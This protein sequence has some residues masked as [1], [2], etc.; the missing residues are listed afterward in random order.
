MH[1]NYCS[2]IF[3]TTTVSCNT[4]LEMGTVG[5]L[6]HGNIITDEKTYILTDGYEVPSDGKVIAW[7][8]CYRTSDVMPV[9]FYPGIW[10]IT[11]VK[12]NGD[13]DYELVQSNAITYDPSKSNNPFSCLT[14]NLSETDQYVVS[15]GSFVGLYSHIGSSL[16][17]TS[18]DDSLI[19]YE[20]DGN[21][22][23]ITKARPDKKEDVNFN[24]AI[25]AYIGKYV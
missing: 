5:S 11:K 7:K 3:C 21:Q 16:L 23:T 8:F 19:T 2:N 24:I 1:F 4:C 15:A 12:S 18:M 20:D 14:L 22:T 10:R 13:T 6:S 25:G 9:T 17:R